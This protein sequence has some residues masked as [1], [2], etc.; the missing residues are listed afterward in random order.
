MPGIGIIGGKFGGGAGGSVSV[1]VSDASPSLGDTI[2][3]TA[4]NTGFTGTVTNKF[5]VK[6][7]LGNDDIITQVGDN[8]YDYV[9][10]FEGT[11]DIIVLAEDGSG[12]TAKGDT[13]ITVGSFYDKYGFDAAWNA[14]NA[15][16]VGNQIDEV[17]DAINSYDASAPSVSERCTVISNPYTGIA[18]MKPSGGQS[19]QRLFTTYPENQSSIT[20]TLVFQYTRSNEIGR[21]SGVSSVLLSS[22]SSTVTN[23]RY[24]IAFNDYRV[25]PQ[26]MFVDVLT[27]G[28][29]SQVRII[30]YPTLG[31]NRAVFKFDHTTGDIRLI[32]NGTEYTANQ[33]SPNSVTGNFQLMNASFTTQIGFT[34]PVNEICMKGDA[35]S[36]SEQDQMYQDLLL[37]FPA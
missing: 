20:Y 32:F 19:N 34:E 27:S 9:C 37:R 13:S 14:A 36:D 5:I 3:I 8:T 22:D 21:A 25:Q 35:V 10:P 33:P 29:V 23:R 17:P 18:G 12:N 4:T 7:F 31:T 16:L 28:G 11:F 6:N 1:A 15:V 30:V 24:Y 2:T 26:Q